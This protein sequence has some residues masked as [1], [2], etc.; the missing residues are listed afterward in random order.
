MLRHIQALC[1]NEHMTKIKLLALDLDGTLL[2]HDKKISDESKRAIKAAQAKGVH[3]VITTGRPLRAIE[4]I[5]SELDL[6]VDTEYSITFN[7]GLVQRNNGEILSKKTFS[8]D[9]IKEI[10]EVFAQLDLPFDVV[11]EGHCYE[12]NPNS[13]Y[14]KFSPFLDF[15]MGE[16]DTIPKDIIYNKAVSAIDA[17]YLDQQMT[18]IPAELKEKYEIFKSRDILLEIMPKGVVKSFGLEKLIGILGIDRENVM[19]MG[20]EENDIAMLTWAGLGV[21]MKNATDQVKA[22]SDM[23]TPLTNDEHGV[24]WAINTYI[25][26]D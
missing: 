18:K 7:G 6:L 4:H 20:D 16:F 14:Q 3:V 11:S 10:H 25:L 2:T 23:T 5:L 15:T 17:D 8:Y 12:T 19:A 13:L 24:A 1:Y 9:N 22:I 26:E 21:A